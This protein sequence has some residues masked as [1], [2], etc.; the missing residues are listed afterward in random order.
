MTQKSLWIVEIIIIAIVLLVIGS[1]AG[2][3]AGVAQSPES[4][5][6]VTSSG[7]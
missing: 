3:K 5:Q 7:K 2:P 6:P 1:I 4:D